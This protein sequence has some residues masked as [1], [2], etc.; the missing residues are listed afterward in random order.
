T[1][2]MSLPTPLLRL[3]FALLLAAALSVAPAAARGLKDYQHTVWSEQHGAPADI[4][5]LAQTADG[6]LWIASSDGLFRFDGVGFEAY[7]PAGLP[8]LAHMRVVDM[9]AAD[10]GDL[11]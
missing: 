8:G 3:A 11:Y 10:N 7:A 4:T 6:W 1:T 5:G 9:Y 2:A